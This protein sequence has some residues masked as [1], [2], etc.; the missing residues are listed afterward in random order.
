[1]GGLFGSTILDVAIGLIFVYLLLAILC[2]AANELVSG[3]LKARAKMLEKGI[4]QLLNNQPTL[5]DPKNTSAFL[6]A[7]YNHPLITG[8]M[9]GSIHPAYLPPRTFATVIT[10][11]MTLNK[12]GS[13]TFA[14]LENGVKAIPDGSVKTALLALVQ[15]SDQDLEAALKAIEGWFNDAMDRVSGWYKRRTQV[16]IIVLA[17]GITVLSNA[18]T[19]HITRRLWTD[20]VLRSA[21]I[22]E[23]KNRAQKPRPSVSVEYPDKDDP[24]NPTVTA[25]DGNRLSEQEQNLLGQMLGWQGN[26]IHDPFTVWLERLL[27]WILTILAISL[28]A[29]FWFDLL[30][31]FM[32]V[33][34]TG[35]SP[36]EAAKTPEKK[37]LPPKDKEA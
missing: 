1:M 23:A 13:I 25:T 37:K 15:R 32:N 21:V 19:L 4:A 30:N 36:D 2:T 3:L 33:R 31:K 35:K 34:S 11:L 27:G 29:P 16:W 20:P 18:D 17:I 9:Q 8:M 7:F 10:D 26:P 12:P 6:K 28:G 14:D 5:A 22:E 24:T